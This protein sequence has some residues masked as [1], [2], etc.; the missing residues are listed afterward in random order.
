MQLSLFQVGILGLFLY[1]ALPA[2]AQCVFLFNHYDTLVI[3]EMG[4]GY[5]LTASTPQ[6]PF[7]ATTNE[8]WLSLS[9]NDSTITVTSTQSNETPN[10]RTGYITISQSGVCTETITLVQPGKTCLRGIDGT[11]GRKFWAAFLENRYPSSEKTLTTNLVFAAL[12]TASGT[13]TN[14]HTGWSSSFTVPAKDIRTVHIPEAQAYNTTGET[15][16]ERAVYIETSA[17]VSVYAVNFQEMTSD[18]AVILPVEALGDEYYSISFNGNRGQVNTSDDKAPEE[19]L[20]VATENN[21]IVT[22]VPKSKTGGGKPAGNPYT[23]RLQKGQSYLVKSDVTGTTDSEL[24]Y[25]SITGSYIKSNKLVAVFAGHKRAHVGCYGD[26][27]RDHLYEQLLPLRLWGTQ[28][29]VVPT[30]LS[31]DLYRVLAI[32]DN[33]KFSINDTEQ[34][35]LNKG[36]YRDFSIN[37]NETAF[38]DADHPVSV[39]LF[40]KSMNCTGMQIGDPF[41]II[42]NPAQNMTKELTFTP[43]PS[44]N[45]PVHYINITVGKQSKHLTRLVNESTGKEVPVSFTDIPSRDYAYA[46]IPIE[47][48]THSLTNEMGFTAYAYGAGNAD[49]YGYLVGARFNHLQEPEMVRDTAYCVDETPQPLSVFDGND[50]LWYTTNDF[51]QETGSTAAPIFSTSS[52]ATYI[53]YVSY[54]KECSESPRKKLTI[55]VENPPN[56]PV[57][58]TPIS[59]SNASFCAGENDTLT[60]YS[61]TAEIFEWYRNNQK[62]D[63]ASGATLSVTESGTYQAKA[64]T[65]HLCY[66]ANPSNLFEVTAHELPGAP[67]I[68][69][70]SICK[71]GVI[72]SLPVASSGNYLV[73]YNENSAEINEPVLQNSAA[74]TTTY[75]ISQ[76]SNATN[77]EGA[78]A[79]W[80]YTVNNLPDVTISGTSYFCEKSDT[81]LTASGAI[82]YLWNTGATS[83]SITVNTVGA[84]SVTGT[85][86]NSCKNTAQVTISEKPLPFVKAA[87]N[88]TTVCHGSSLWLNVLGSTTGTV[89]WNVAYPVIIDHTQY[90]IAIATNE[91]GSFRDSALVTHVPLP[92]V[93]PMDPL[94]TCENSEII[95]TVKSAIGDI[96]WNVPDTIFTAVASDTYTVYATNLCGTASQTVP[97]TVVPLPR[98]VANNDTTVCYE[99]GVTLC[100]Q[101][102]TGALSWNGPPTVKVTGPQTYTVTASNECGTVSDE[103]A[104]DIFAPIRFTVPNPLPPYKYKRYYEQELSFENAEHPVYLR[105]L[106]S[107]PDGMMITADGILR[108]TPMVTGYNFNSH[109]FTLFLEDSH[110]CTTSQ[111]FSLP[112]LFSA[113][114][115]IIRDGGENS[116]FLPDF[117]LEIYN[118]QGI[119]LHKG[120]GWLGTSGSSQVSPG[121]YF[122][123]VDVMQDGEQHQYMGYIT[124]LQ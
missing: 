5:A 22:I 66:A 36:E 4:S 117:N 74:E 56:D 78:A 86:H 90:I 28:Y 47:E 11:Q 65:S 63:G 42:L 54:L 19:F 43:L 62:I 80:V 13:I 72:P 16:N 109:H 95:L 52:P 96:H 48:A 71:T 30:H 103:M 121:T 110:S 58:G 29:L 113:P 15:I 93:A 59:Q 87:L 81:A 118:R 31:Q 101:Q 94:R 6:V 83:A 67:D 9:K 79:T 73:W 26:N 21:T 119:L 32:H 104:V 27:N 14:P 99:R 100:T 35:P 34:A 123:K 50:L 46:R 102:H 97:V 49:S 85:D 38:I 44:S 57:I 68:S 25:A 55:V 124:V 82:S 12:H 91:C 8:T 37:Q 98:V 84:Y 60:V 2:S 69:N 116:H 18:A 40:A 41:M 106:G 45:I 89:S 76:K 122:Y 7:N 107:L 51:E 105:W 92:A 17:D 23:V 24:N 120:K 112:P 20:I 77:C 64:A 111:E 33:T 114:N 75:Y 53:Y 108:G 10:Q 61:A 88:D 1:T 39:A 3:G 70:T 115:T